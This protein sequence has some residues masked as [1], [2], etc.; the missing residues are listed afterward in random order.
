MNWICYLD[1]FFWTFFFIFFL[2]VEISTLNLITIWFSAGS[3]LNAILTLFK[4][5]KA[6]PVFGQDVSSLIPI[7]WQF[8]I[9]SIFSI[10]CI[11]FFYSKLKNKINR[12]RTYTNVEAMAGKTGFI[13]Q[14][15]LKNSVGQVKI[16]GQIWTAISEDNQPIPADEE[17]IVKSIQGVKA[18]VAL[19][20]KNK[21][22]ETE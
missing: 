15:I 8:I 12:T 1:T 20:I 9:F 2:I 18:I 21:E 6:T 13:T 7:L 17:I 3:L 11:V 16:D 4:T 5:T 10:L 19:K 22:E 14:P